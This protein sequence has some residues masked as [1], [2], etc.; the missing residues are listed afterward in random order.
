MPPLSLVRVIIPSHRRPIQ[1]QS[2]VSC[3]AGV[4]GFEVAVIENGNPPEVSARYR[5]LL[6]DLPGV[7]ILSQSQPN[8]S[9]ARNLGLHSATTKWVWFFDDDDRVSPATLTDLRL[10]LQGPDPA[11]NIVLP[12]RR[13]RGGEIVSDRSPTS[14]MHTYDVYR[15][16]G[17]LVGNSSSR[18]LQ[19]TLISGIGGWDESL[20]AGHD[21]DLFLRLVRDGATFTPLETEPVF[22][23]E[24]APDR[25]SRQ[26]WRQ[27][28]GATQLLYKHWT[29]LS[30]KRRAIYLCS[31]V[32]LRPLWRH[33]IH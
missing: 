21:T 27:M 4:P 13:I 9:K 19:R 7:T 26:A 30:R 2:A 12:A 33:L 20:A 17:H 5:Q 15:D 8:A 22:I 24:D 28:R 10:A 29:H 31:L 3:F 23:Y 6:S 25:L 18:V 11:T 1:C 14:T 16:A 32:S